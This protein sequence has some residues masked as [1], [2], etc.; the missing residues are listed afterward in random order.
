MNAPEPG[1]SLDDVDH[2][3]VMQALPHRYPML[4]VDRVTQLIAHQSAVGI[5][6]VSFNEPHFAGHFPHDPIM[7]GVLIIEALG[8]TA[9]VLMV[10]SLGTDTRGVSVYFM[11]IDEARFRR[12]VRPG[13]QLQLAVE[14]D[15]AKLGVWR[16][17][18]RALV[19]G[20]MVAEASFSAR[21]V[22]P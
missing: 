12:P 2:A 8:Q 21:L 6:N 3:G 13:D 14:L 18:G 5:K 16:F 17:K 15:R 9:G 19:E 1:T 10:R 4:M 22:G 20:K 11:A 7:P